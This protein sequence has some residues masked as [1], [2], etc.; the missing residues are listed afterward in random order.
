M[1]RAMR[2]EI[3]LVDRPV[4]PHPVEK[5]ARLGRDDSLDARPRVYQKCGHLRTRDTALLDGEATDLLC[6]ERIF[7]G[8]A[9]P[10]LVV[11]REDDPTP[12]SDPWQPLVVARFLGE[13]GV[14]DLNLNSDSPERIGDDLPTER[15]VAED[16]HA[17]VVRTPSK[18]SACSICRREMP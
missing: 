7:F 16:D 13:V 17:A 12:L 2:S 6:D 4:A 11:L 5:R 3:D 9:P 10:H 1:T 18:S 14:V 8:R 15:A